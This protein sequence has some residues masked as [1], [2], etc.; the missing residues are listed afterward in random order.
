[1]QIQHDFGINEPQGLALS[2]DLWRLPLCSSTAVLQNNDNLKVARSTGPDPL[3]QVCT[4]PCPHVHACT[5]ALQINPYHTFTRH[6]V[7]RYALG[8]ADSLPLQCAM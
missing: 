1:M 2:I 5:I 4:T 7:S 6:V 8:I 3:L